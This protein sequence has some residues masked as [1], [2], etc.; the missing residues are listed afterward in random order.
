[1]HS[2][3]GSRFVGGCYRC[4]RP[5]SS[6]RRPEALL[7]LQEHSGIVLRSFWDRSGIVLGLFPAILWWE[8]CQ[9][10][11]AAFGPGGRNTKALKAI[12]G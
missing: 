2:F 1:M 12:L 8:G 5:R 6:Q 4:V 3:D 11:R 10:T 7:D 9:I